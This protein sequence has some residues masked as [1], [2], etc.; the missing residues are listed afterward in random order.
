MP[1]TSD[2]THDY[3]PLTPV[4]KIPFELTPTQLGKIK[5]TMKSIKDLFFIF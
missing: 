2:Q 3:I 4:P 5:T 1:Y